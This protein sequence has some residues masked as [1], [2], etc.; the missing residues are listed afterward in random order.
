MGTASRIAV[1]SH[2]G[3]PPTPPPRRRPLFAP[4]APPLRPRIL[5]RS[6]RESG[7]DDVHARRSFDFGQ[8]RPAPAR[9]PPPPPSSGQSRA[10]CR[11]GRS[12]RVGA[13]PAT[14]I[15]NVRPTP[16]VA[17]RPRVRRTVHRRSASI[18][19]FGI[20]LRAT[21]VEPPP[22][23]PRFPPV[24][25]HSQPFARI[26]SSFAHLPVAADSYVRGAR[27][28][29]RPGLPIAT[30]GSETRSFFFFAGSHRK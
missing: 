23:R 25:S 19:S 15:A 5:S 28:P 13:P 21:Y 30:L 1:G 22:A 6:R 3:P 27:A 20:P 11:W 24:R 17:P 12:L 29:S 4:G 2:G 16:F 14:S 7:R 18:A 9:A 10:R 26:G 8:I